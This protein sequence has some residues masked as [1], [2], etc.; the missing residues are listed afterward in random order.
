MSTLQHSDMLAKSSLDQA[1]FNGKAHQH[2]IFYSN[3]LLPGGIAFGSW[4]RSCYNS[5]AISNLLVSGPSSL[6]RPMPVEQDLL[7]F[8]QLQKLMYCNSLPRENM[9][10][11]LRL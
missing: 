5:R 6:I 11:L 10:Q 3:K 4:P 1:N 7:M 8:E 2:P 9:Q